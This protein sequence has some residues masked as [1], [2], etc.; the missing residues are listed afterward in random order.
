MLDFQASE[1]RSVSA[2]IFFAVAVVAAFILLWW[3]R[4]ALLLGFAATVVAIVI[5]AAARPLRRKLPHHWAVAIAIVAIAGGLGLL[6][7][8]IG[9]RISAQLGELSAE[10]PKAIQEFERYT[11]LAVPT[12]SET[13]GQDAAASSLFNGISG[14]LLNWSW[15]ALMAAGTLV[16]V[17]IGGAFFALNPS[18]YRRG[19]VSLFPARYRKGADASLSEAGRALRLWLLGQLI[20]MSIIGLVVALGAWLIGL[21]APLALGL[22][23]GVAEFIPMLGPLL[24]A[25]P[26]L[27]L[28]LSQ[29]PTT[30]LWTIGLFLA[31]Q[32]LESNIIMPQVQREMV[33][34]PP[35]LFLFS[36]LAFGILFGV[37]GIFLA[38]PLTV[39]TFALVR[40]LVTEET[41]T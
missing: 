19:F 13:G 23:A 20:S 26:A 27:L 3:L 40:R 8:L 41:S 29:G 5:L 4:D 30:V 39:T 14:R 21:P 18:V 10:L 37:I 11:G 28:A 2:Y 17:L 7:W 6:G 9:G 15:T 36:V 32:Q 25:V 34:I 1:Q 12:F 22:L 24:G 16:L 31:I 33:H 35:A 38:G